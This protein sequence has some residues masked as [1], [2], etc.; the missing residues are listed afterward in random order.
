[1]IPDKQLNAKPMQN[2]F[3]VQHEEGIQKSADKSF[4]LCGEEEK[5]ICLSVAN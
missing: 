4:F 5:V 1:M 2:S 3:R